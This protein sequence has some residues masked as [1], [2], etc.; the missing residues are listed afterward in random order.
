MESAGR[1]VFCVLSVLKYY[2]IIYYNK[3]KL[4]I[5]C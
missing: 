2:K 4:K 1:E 3:I 5:V